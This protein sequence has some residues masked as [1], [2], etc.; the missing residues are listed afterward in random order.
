MYTCPPLLVSAHRFPTHPAQCLP[1]LL[2]PPVDNVIVVFASHDVDAVQDR[3]V[4]LCADV[5]RG[6]A[7]VRPEIKITGPYHPD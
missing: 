1:V 2:N 7:E 3:H 5:F 4:V 6:L